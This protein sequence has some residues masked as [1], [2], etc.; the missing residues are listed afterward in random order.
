MLLTFVR[1]K[2]ASGTARSNTEDRLHIL[3]TPHFFKAWDC[4]SEQHIIGELISS[5]PGDLH[6]D[7]LNKWLGTMQ[8]LILF[9]LVFFHFPYD[10]RA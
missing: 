1:H 6:S 10:R 5:I 8:Y 7:E 9:Q 3:S 4:L 2:T